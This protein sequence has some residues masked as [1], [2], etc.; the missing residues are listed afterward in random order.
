MGRFS[1]AKSVSL[2]PFFV[3]DTLVGYII[4]TAPTGYIL[5]FFG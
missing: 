5:R 4:H 1:E 2:E 3:D